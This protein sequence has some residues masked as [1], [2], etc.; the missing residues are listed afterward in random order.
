LLEKHFENDNRIKFLVT[1]GQD[2]KYNIYDHTY[3][4]SHGAQFK[5]GDS[6]IGPL[7]PITRGDNK[8][9]GWASQVDQ[10]YKTS[11]YGH[12]H[13]LIILQH[14]IVNGSLVGRDEFC[15]NNNYPY[16]PPYQALWITNPNRGI[17]ITAPVHAAGIIKSQ[18]D[19]SW[20]TWPKS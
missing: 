6:I 7:G 3:R 12:F 9:R 11:L 10:Q 8:K 17:T 15:H 16:E 13:R 5:G 18:K 20:V 1:A 19:T 2:A 14:I 4:M